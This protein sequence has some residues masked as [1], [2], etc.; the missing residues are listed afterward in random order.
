MGLPVAFDLADGPVQLTVDPGLGGRIASVRVDGLEVLVTAGASPLEQ[1]WY[2]MAPFAGRLRAGR[3]TFDGSEHHVPLTAW[4]NAIHGTVHAV[5]WVVEEQDQT[6]CTLVADLGS[7]WPFQGQVRHRIQLDHLDVRLSLEITSDGPPFPASCGWH[8]WFRR[9]LDTGSPV[10]V[11]LDA[12][13]MWERGD[14]TLPTG[15]LVA[16]KPGPWDDCFTELTAP[17]GLR[18]PGA[19]V[20]EVVTSCEHIVVFDERPEGVCIEPQTG[21]PDALNLQPT[22]VAP[23]A[24]LGAEA[25]FSFRWDEPG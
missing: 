15:R 19:L 22:V 9:V 16:P 24:P 10:E 18:W 23:G 6:S 17:A 3:F 7:T 12:R 25:T 1:G 20:L 2:P 8:P 4:P 14:D 5:P 13:A 21:P 11:H